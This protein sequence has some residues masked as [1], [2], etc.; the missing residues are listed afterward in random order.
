M[1]VERLIVEYERDN[2]GKGEEVRKAWIVK[3]AAE[4]ANVAEVCIQCSRLRIGRLTLTA[5]PIMCLVVY[6]K[7]AEEGSLAAGKAEGEGAAVSG[8][9]LLEALLANIP[10]RS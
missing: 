6:G 5:R 2:H 1:A 8:S 7:A 3:R 4:H 9:C 10:A